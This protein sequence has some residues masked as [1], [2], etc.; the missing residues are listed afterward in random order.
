MCVRARNGGGFE[1]SNRLCVEYF[2]RR[3]GK[4]WFDATGL[5]RVRFLL[6]GEPGRLASASGLD[7]SCH[8]GR[9]ASPGR[10]AL[11]IRLAW[12]LRLALT[13][14]LAAPPQRRPFP[15]HRRPGRVRCGSGRECSRRH[16][17]P[18]SFRS[19]VHRVK[20]RRFCRRRAANDPLRAEAEAW[21]AAISVQRAGEQVARNR[22]Q[23]TG[24]KE[25][26]ALNWRFGAIVWRGRALIEIRSRRTIFASW[27]ARPSKTYSGSMPGNGA[28]GGKTPATA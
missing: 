4:K 22:S 14:R 6:W 5:K 15:A 12:R 25:P 9:F 27:M 13:I 21:R 28:G 23:G 8:P 2:R 24:C 16:E 26:G 20:A 19:L 7:T 3:T 10:F 18:V 1:V 17:W 11:T